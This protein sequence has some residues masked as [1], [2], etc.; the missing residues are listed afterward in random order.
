VPE[1]PRHPNSNYPAKTS[2]LPSGPRDAYT[3]R[4]IGSFDHLAPDTVLSAVEQ[5]FG[6][7]LDGTMDPFPS[8]INRVYGLRDEGGSQYVVK[9]Y[10]PGRWDY[11][12]VREEHGFLLECAGAG[13][14]V[15]PP[16]ADAEG[17]TL[18]ELVV[19]GEDAEFLFALFPKRGGRSFDPESDQDWLRLGSVV[20]R[21]HA[22]GRQASAAHRLVCRPESLTAGFL[23]EI[24]A[25]QL[26]HPDCRRQFEEVCTEALELITPLFQGVGLQRVHGDCHRGNILDR[27]AEG[28]LLIDFD[29]MMN[30]PPVQDLWL[31][32]PGHAHD[33][34]RE[35]QLLVEGYERF[36]DFDRSSLRL[37]EPLRFMRMVYFL[38][39]RS[40]Q[41]HDHWFARAFPD[42]GGK[43]FWI[44]EAEDLR[45]QL[46]AIRET[47][48][49]GPLL[50]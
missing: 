7:A 15:V 48:E 31:L 42:W 50:A 23:E 14:P 25:A 11:D 46:G 44:K 22:V 3:A 27:E 5:A 24:R 12:S 26:V 1:A 17:E 10:R 30:A 35:L 36:L 37:I 16:I 18:G 49:A 20:G 13:L 21:L 29:D 33:C 47:L 41:R 34:R 2:V 45:E 6:L 4:V 28:L 38:A 43:P 40:R 32:L 8:Y 39:W 19:G 9:F